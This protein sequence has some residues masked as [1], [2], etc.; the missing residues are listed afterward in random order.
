ML[1]SALWEPMYLLKISVTNAIRRDAG[2]KCTA[3]AVVTAGWGQKGGAAGM[4]EGR[5]APLCPTA[6]RQM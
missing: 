3:T 6:Q 4:R 5:Q 2:C 1:M